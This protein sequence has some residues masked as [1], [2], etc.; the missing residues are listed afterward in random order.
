MASN[1]RFVTTFSISILPELADRIDQ[2]AEAERRSRSQWITFACE[3]K[4]ERDANKN[5][6]EIPGEAEEGTR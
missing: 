5:P 1:K 6:P 4:L 2:A 3:E